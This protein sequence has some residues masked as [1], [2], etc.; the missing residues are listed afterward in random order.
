[1]EVCRKLSG[2]NGETKTLV[3]VFNMSENGKLPEVDM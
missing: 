2:L 1:V 3:E